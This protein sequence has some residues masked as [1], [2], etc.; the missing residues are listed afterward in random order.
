MIYF[1]I[2]RE[3]SYTLSWF[4]SDWSSERFRRHVQF[5]PYDRLPLL[6]EIVP[7]AFIF[8]DLE[9]LNSF[10]LKVAKDFYEQLV[11]F[12]KDMPVLNNPGCALDRYN[13]LQ[14]L[15]NSGFNQFRV[16]RAADKNLRPVYP[17]FLRM[18]DDHS[19]PRS[20]LLHNSQEVDLAILQAGMMG[21]DINHMLLIEY[22]ETK[23]NAGFYRKYAAFRIA[24]QIIPGHLLFNNDWLVK[25][26][27]PPFEQSHEVEK[28]KYI[29]EN[30][31]EE[32]LREIFKLAGI[33]Y[34]RIDYSILNGALQTWEINTNPVLNQPR[35]KL[36]EERKELIPVKEKLAK[37]LEGKLLSLD[38]GGD[39]AEAAKSKQ[40]IT[41]HWDLQKYT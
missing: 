11:F 15:H 9:R 18:A 6:K 8:S 30:P 28:E 2:T 41:L 17:V 35:Q 38:Y 24:D 37:R 23:D 34:G 26:G 19:G 22:C 40:R 10:Q 20:K 25:E 4:L 7:A 36:L 27:K 16:Y 14:T 33:T 21:L 29:A 12:D 1:C 32:K 5:I 13:L 3:H 39:V 31:H